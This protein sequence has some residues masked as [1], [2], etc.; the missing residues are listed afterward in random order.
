MAAKRAGN[1]TSFVI[2]LIFV[3]IS[4]WWGVAEFFH[5]GWFAPYG[6]Y[7]IFYMLPLLLLLT[8]LFLSQL[9]PL[10][11]GGGIVLAAFAFTI[12]RYRMLHRLG[13]PLNITQLL[14]PLLVFSLPGILLLAEGRRRKREEKIPVGK[15]VKLVKRRFVLAIFLSLMILFGIG[16]PLLINNLNRVPLRSFTHQEIKGNNIVRI[17]VGKGP[18]WYYS[19]RFPFKFRGKEFSALSWNEI[20]LFGKKPV[21]FEGKRFGPGGSD[22]NPKYAGQKD[23]NE[24]NMF[25]YLSE[26]GTQLTDSILDIWYLPSVSEYVRLMVKRG[27]NAG[28]LFD[29]L[30]GIAEYSV[31]P[32]K[33]APLW[34]PDMEVIYYWTSTSAD[35]L[36]AYDISYNGRVRKVIKTTKQDYRGYRAA[37][38]IIPRK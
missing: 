20:A 9:F 30:K 12:W 2:L 24:Y 35:S 22:K 29:S 17:F 7:L 34:A 31:T 15:R 6:K 14:L 38:N 33:D 13:V 26:D 8:V 23:F 4:A 36:N 25:R 16:I 37:K 10:I 5:E 28:G 1:T 32:D 19:N 27:K 11:T 3:L 18:G 21:G